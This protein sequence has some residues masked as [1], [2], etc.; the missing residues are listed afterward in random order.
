M[1][2]LVQNKIAITKKLETNNSLLK[3]CEWFNDK[4]A[5]KHQIGFLAQYLLDNICKILK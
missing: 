5:L 2:F 1:N 4:N 3:L